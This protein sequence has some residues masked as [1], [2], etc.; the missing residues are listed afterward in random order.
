MKRILLVLPFLLGLTC[1]AQSERIIQKTVNA[2]GKK[3][4]MKFSFAD[5]IVVEAWEKNTIEL[6]VFVNIDNNRYNNYYELKINENGNLCQLTEDVN[7]KEIQKLKGDHC[8][9]ESHIVYQLKV[10]AKQEFDLKTISGKVDLN[11]ALGKMSVNSISGFIDYAVPQSHKARIDLST[12]TGN[13][14]SDLKF[15]EK[16]SKE[17]SWVGNKRNLTLNGGDV[18]VALKTVSGD[19]FLRKSR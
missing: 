19:I 16:A 12:V 13:V 10:P 15:E 6:K 2:Q 18:A 4:E 5:S 3:V 7:F 8:N 14:Y 17:V 1:Y 9:M 11:G